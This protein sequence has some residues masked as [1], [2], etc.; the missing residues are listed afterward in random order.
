[1]KKNLRNSNY[2]QLTVA[3]TSIC[4]VY[5]FKIFIYSFSLSLWWV[6]S[7]IVQ[8]GCLH[9]DWALGGRGRRFHTKFELPLFDKHQWRCQVS[10]PAPLACIASA[11]PFELHPLI[12]HLLGVI[13]FYNLEWSAPQWTDRCR[14]SWI[15]H[16]FFIIQ[17]ETVII[18]KL[19]VL[20]YILLTAGMVI[21][22][23]IL[24]FWVFKQ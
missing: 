2:L 11:L 14:N 8:Q 16:V 20:N 3:S 10:I 24:L 15:L 7:I 17:V 23:H 1:M 13:R 5:S 9:A 19:W 12:S 18:L 21:A 6:T 22:N 4:S